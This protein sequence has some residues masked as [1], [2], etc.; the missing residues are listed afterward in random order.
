MAPS[1]RQTSVPA[2][3]ASAW[4]A[5]PNASARPPR[6]S[7]APTTPRRRQPTAATTNSRT[8][9]G[10]AT[11]RDPRANHHTLAWAEAPVLA[12]RRTAVAMDG[13]DSALPAVDLGEPH[14]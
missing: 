12:R 3:N 6:R 4:N 10:D 14:G 11:E 5:R 7:A 13:R 8:S 9:S 1:A 2:P